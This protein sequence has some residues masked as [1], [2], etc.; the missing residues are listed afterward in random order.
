MGAVEDPLEV[1]I[2]S[3][4]ELG[5][6]V[7]ATLEDA[8]GNTPLDILEEGGSRPARPMTV[9]EKKRRKRSCQRQVS[10]SSR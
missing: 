9:R 8:I 1:G 4:I 2:F 3:G 5:E 6:G 10:H 7:L